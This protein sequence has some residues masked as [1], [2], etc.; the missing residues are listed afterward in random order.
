[1]KDIMIYNA[2]KD[3]DECSLIL[4]DLDIIFARYLSNYISSKQ[5][6][7]LKRISYK[8]EKEAFEIYGSLIEK[9]DISENVIQI[10]EIKKELIRVNN[11]VYLMED[12]KLY[13]DKEFNI[14]ENI[15]CFI[16]IEEV[17]K[18]NTLSLIMKRI[19]GILVSIKL[20]M[21]TIII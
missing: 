14:D 18:Y 5:Y 3:I 21:Q 16:K 17:L 13:L 15:I 11:E 6:I 2:L 19:R 1:M 10:N 9:T 12:K 4:Y 8:L 20:D 7:D